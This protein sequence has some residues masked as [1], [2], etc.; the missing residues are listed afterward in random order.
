[1]SD[2]HEHARDLAEA[3]LEALDTG[4]EARADALL[5]EAKKLDKSAVVELIEDL[6]EDAGSAPAVA[7][8]RMP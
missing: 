8:Q 4:D 6:D 1:M 5:A 7:G 3:A 2:K